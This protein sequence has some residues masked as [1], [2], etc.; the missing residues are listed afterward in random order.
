MIIWPLNSSGRLPW[1]DKAPSYKAVATSVTSCCGGKER[2]IKGSKHDAG[3]AC[4]LAWCNWVPHNRNVL[5]VAL[6]DFHPEDL[7][8]M[9]QGRISS[10]A[11]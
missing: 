9:P 5:F 3:S 10:G 1:L 11:F 8:Y 2:E 4:N 6:W 7:T